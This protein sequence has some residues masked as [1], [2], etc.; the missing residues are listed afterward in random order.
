[1]PTASPSMLVSSSAFAESSAPSDGAILGACLAGPAQD[2]VGSMNRGTANQG[3]QEAG[4]VRRNRISSMGPEQSAKT[5]PA[6][7]IQRPRNAGWGTGTPHQRAYPSQRCLPDTR[8]G[9][10]A[11]LRLPD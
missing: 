3:V 5:S 8:C 9:T 1:M 6:A 2:V 7:R 10:P 11:L 4:E